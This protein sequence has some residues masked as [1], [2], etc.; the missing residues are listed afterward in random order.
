MHGRRAG[1][2]PAVIALG[3][4]ILLAGCELAQP[5]PAYDLRV[6]YQALPDDG[7][8]PSPADLEVIRTIVESRLQDTGIATLRVG[9]EEPDRVVVEFAPASA[10]DELRALAGTTGR[11]DFVPLGDVEMAPGDPI[12][13]GQHPPLFSA[14][15][16]ASASY[17]VSQT[18][19]PTVDLTL[20]DEARRV[21]ADY[22][23]ANVG[24]SFAIALDGE[25]LTVPVI[26]DPILGGQVQVSTAGDS[27]AARA[28][29]QRLITVLRHGQLPYPL[30]EIAV[31]NL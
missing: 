15:Q 24:A 2:A 4:T 25:V 18:G 16:V 20:K 27:A 17:G 31:E 22:T 12:D 6:T 7:R 28:T 14:D 23:T 5:S 10:G 30:R 1:P 8:T 9:V 19:G 11:V 29:A 3:A 13:L 21:F 26:R